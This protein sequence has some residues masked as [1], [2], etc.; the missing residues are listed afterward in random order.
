MSRV[1][2]KLL[3]TT[4]GVSAGTDEFFNETTLLLHGDGTNGSQNNTFIDSSANGFTITRN[5]NTTQ[6]SYSPYGDRWSNYFDGTGDYLDAG[7]DAALNFGTGDFTIECWVNFASTSGELGLFSKYS[8]APRGVNLRYTSSSTALR[9]VAIG[10]GGTLAQNVSFNPIIGAWYHIAY[11]RSG[12]NHY[13]YVD[14]T[15]IFSQTSAIGNI[16]TSEP[17][18]VGLSQTVSNSEFNGYISDVRAIKGTALYTTNF[19]PPTEPLTAVTN[20]SLLTCQS[21]RFKDNSSNDFAITVNGNTKVTPFSPYAPSDAYDPANE[22]GSGYF[23][24]SGDYL[25][26]GTDTAYAFGTGDFTIECWFYAVTIDD[27]SE[28][29]VSINTASSSADWQLNVTTD[30][31]TQLEFIASSSV[32]LT[33]PISA[34]QWYHVAVVRSGSNL[35]LYLNGIQVDTTTNT[36]NFSDTGPL[37]VGVNRGG[38][39][40]FNGYISDVRIIKGTALYTSDFT[41]PTAPLTAVTNTSLLCNF[42]NA[43]IFDSTGKSVLET[44]GNAQIDTTTVKYGTGSMEFDGTGDYLVVNND[45]TFSGDFTVELWHNTTQIT[46]SFPSPRLFCSKGG[47]GNIAD[48]FQITINSED[49]TN[50]GGSLLLFS[51]ESLSDKSTTSL[52]DGNWHHIAAT[53]SGTD[54]KLFIDG[55]QQGSTYTSSQAF[56]FSNSYIGVRGDLAS[57]TY[58]NGYID[59]FRITKGVARYTANFTP[60]TKAFPDQ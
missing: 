15:E 13:L 45:D 26:A 58:Y 48:N 9:L 4:G 3:S 49:P 50:T 12:D 31:G 36:N 1:I 44:V 39:K 32:V 57:G 10:T 46:N 16:D 5:G 18:V 25:S 28:S 20:T 29:L 51:N 60:P 59:D 11:S 14:G 17:F 27:R 55:V 42:T 7:S 38:F 35:N 52:S 23:D 37:R 24:G 6:G 21:N 47:S 43:G 22:G 40:N 19:T 41:P 56:T 8:S 34:G 53:R 2:N 30:N 54:V 33:Y